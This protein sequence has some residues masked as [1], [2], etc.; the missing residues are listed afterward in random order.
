ML[1]VDML[2]YYV[3]RRILVC[4]QKISVEYDK[5]SQIVISH[6]KWTICS[7]I[8]HAE[9]LIVEIVSAG[10]QLKHRFNCR[11][12]FGIFVWSFQPSH[13]MRTFFQ[14]LWL[15]TS[16]TTSIRKYWQ[17]SVHLTIIFF[18]LKYS[19]IFPFG[20]WY[21]II[22][23]LDCDFWHDVHCT[24]VRVDVLQCNFSFN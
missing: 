10:A 2:A 8:R 5:N 6:N 13:C 12:Y 17:E 18:F 1:R 24:A 14:T 7:T 3:Y 23:D 15:A 4:T 21:A 9:K 20:Q 19:T 22:V 11:C 16:D